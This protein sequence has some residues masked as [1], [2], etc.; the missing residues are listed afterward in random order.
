MNVP[1]LVL[2]LHVDRPER[3]PL[4]VWLPLFL[5]WPLLFALGVLAL[6]LTLLLDTWLLVLG[7][8]YHHYSM[9]LFRCFEAFTETRGMV[10]RI[11]DGDAAVDMT[12]L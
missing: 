4:H 7:R 1:P 11:N 3:G 2:D 5:L 10:I 8:R 6:V 12:L 9:L